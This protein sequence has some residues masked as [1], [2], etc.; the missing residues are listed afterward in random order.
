MINYS[1]PVDGIFS[2]EELD[3]HLHSLE[4]MRDAVPYVT[5]YYEPAWG[6]CMS[7]EQREA[8]LDEHYKVVIKSELKPG[9]LTIGELYIL[10]QAKR[11]FY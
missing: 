6:F 11:D 4:D 2:K 3:K 1:T 9:A 7:H 8:L 5:A 10:V